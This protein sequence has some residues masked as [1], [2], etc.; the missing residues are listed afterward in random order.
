MTNE[1]MRVA[2]LWRRLAA[3]VYDALLLIALMMVATAM[4]LPFTGGEPV[5]TAGPLLIAVHRLVLVA[6][7]IGFYG[8]F[9]TQ[10]GQTLGMAAWRM[11]LIRDSGEP[12][13]WADALKRL[14][15]GLL[16]IVPAG[17]GFIW[18]LFDRDRLTWHDRLSHTRPVIRP[19]QRS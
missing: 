18:M 4:F 19:K 11:Q 7:W 17:L 3:L 15:A 8:V 1:G 9:W 2:G 5:S 6:L 10:R 16:S 14:F 13:R 12:L